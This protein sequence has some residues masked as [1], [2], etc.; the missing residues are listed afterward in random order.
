M[1][2]DWE[3]KSLDQIATVKGGKRVPKGYKFETTPTSHP[4]IGLLFDF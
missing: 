3:I 4:Y 2:K 1:R